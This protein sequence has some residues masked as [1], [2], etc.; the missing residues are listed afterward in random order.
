M[1]NTPVASHLAN[2]TE[3]EHDNTLVSALNI[4]Q[5]HAL[6]EPSR[7]AELRRQGW[8]API[9]LEIRQG[10]L[11]QVR[12]GRVEVRQIQAITN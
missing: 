7:R 5:L 10:I 11:A 8:E 1:P 6:F 4:A 3:A 2:L 9:S 12:Y